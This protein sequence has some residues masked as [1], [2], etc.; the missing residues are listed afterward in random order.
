MTASSRRRGGPM[1]MTVLLA[2]VA[3]RTT[4]IHHTEI[5]MPNPIALPSR[6]VHSRHAE[7]CRVARRRLAI[8]QG[9]LALH[10]PPVPRNCPVGTDDPMTGNGDGDRV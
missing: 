3:L 2:E 7:G 5:M 4:R 1:N 6:P 8:E 9:E 10:T